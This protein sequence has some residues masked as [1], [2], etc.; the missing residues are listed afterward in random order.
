M[1]ATR[2]G[3]SLRRW[4]LAHGTIGIIVGASLLCVATD[5]EY[6]PFSQYEMFSELVAT[7]PYAEVVLVGLGRDDGREFSLRPHKYIKPFDWS[8]QRVALERLMKRPDHGPAVARALADI[9][10]RYELRRSRHHGPALQAVRLYQLEWDHANP[11][12]AASVNSEHVDRRVL[13]AEWVVP[14]EGR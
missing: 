14:G 1:S 2:H 8:R 4:R 11:R 12:E 6:W 9:A 7:H 10:R 3:L 13:L 5:R